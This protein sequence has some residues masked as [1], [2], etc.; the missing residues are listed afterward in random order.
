MVV[1]EGLTTLV[2]PEPDGSQVYVVAP[3]AVKVGEAPLQIVVEVGVTVSTGVVTVV[4]VTVCEAPVQLPLEPVTV[5]TVVD[6]G[7]TTLA[8]PEPEGSQVYVV[9]PLAVKVVEAPL[10]IVVEAGVTVKTGMVLTVTVAV[11]GRLAQPP[12]D[13]VSV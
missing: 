2:A 6:D 1:E 12:L 13:P 3:L 9:A 11:L 10:Q 4:T 5:Y 8:A 7:L